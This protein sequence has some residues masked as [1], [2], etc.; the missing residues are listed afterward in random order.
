MFVR[1]VKVFKEKMK[2]ILIE[3]IYLLYKILSAIIPSNQIFY[4]VSTYG[5]ENRARGIP[6][7]QSDHHLVFLSSLLVHKQM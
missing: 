1:V 7:C 4:S 2:A 5:D 6:Q 3:E